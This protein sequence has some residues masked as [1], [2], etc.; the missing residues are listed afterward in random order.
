MK[1]RGSN[2]RRSSNKRERKSKEKK[3]KK[4]KNNFTKNK[5]KKLYSFYKMAFKSQSILKE[6]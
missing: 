5:L 3:K 2:K 1:G 6:E 4:R